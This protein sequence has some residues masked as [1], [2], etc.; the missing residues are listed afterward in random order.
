MSDKGNTVLFKYWYERIVWQY[1][2][3]CNLEIVNDDGR[4][5]WSIAGLAHD[6]VQRQS[7]RKHANPEIKAMVKNL[8]ALGLMQSKGQPIPVLAVAQSSPFVRTESL[9]DRWACP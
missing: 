5:L 8:A 6:S 7:Q 4:N 3:S 9:L 2:T 1:W